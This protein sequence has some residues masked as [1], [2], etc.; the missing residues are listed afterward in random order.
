MY[1]YII[2][3]LILSIML[4]TLSERK[5]QGIIQHRIGP[6][7]V[8][9]YGIL[10]PLVDGIKLIRKE[11]IIPKNS[12]KILYIIAPIYSIIISIIMWIIIIYYDLN[13]TFLILLCL[14]GLEIYGI[15]I[16]GYASKNKYTIIGAIR[17]TSQ[18][19][20]YEL[21]LTLI[22]FF[23]FLIIGSLRFKYL[24]ILP[25]GYIKPLIKLIPIY[26]ISLIIIL[27]ETNRTPFDLA[28]SE[29]ET[30]AGF[31]I[32]YSSII[33][34][35]YY[36]AEYSNM[37][38]LSYLFS[39]FFSF[40]SLF[41]FPFHLFFYLLIRA[42]LPRLRYDFLIYLCWYSLLPISLSFLI[43]FLSLLFLFY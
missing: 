7:Q 15:L 28:E 34:A 17:T 31:F 13:I 41:L 5:V 3:P 22:F 14:G 30:V 18:L 26:I 20:S 39:F 12:I 1:L 42:T 21:I 16:G 4:Y 2:I 19:I 9:I 38:F 29:S 43:L 27:A 37:I 6:N 11:I 40:G 24:L 36:L 32:E 10:Q 35:C 8:G 33:F 25:F 23:F